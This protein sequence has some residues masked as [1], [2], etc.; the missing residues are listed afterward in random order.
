MVTKELLPVGR[1]RL[2]GNLGCALGKQGCAGR[3]NKEEL[4][5]CLGAV[6]SA[7][8]RGWRRQLAK[9][10]FWRGELG[11]TD[12]EALLISMCS[13]PNYLKAITSV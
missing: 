7:A 4:C 8:D 13:C 10:Q 1:E 2:G 9:L 11:S 3:G 5:G 6:G 12:W